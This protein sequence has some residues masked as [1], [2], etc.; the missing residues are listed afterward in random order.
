MPQGIL[1]FKALGG[2]RASHK[3]LKLMK[4][5]MHQCPICGNV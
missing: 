5:R 3:R 4:P 2:H 1:F